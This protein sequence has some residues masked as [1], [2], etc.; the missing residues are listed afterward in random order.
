M[1]KAYKHETL[2]KMRSPALYVHR[3]LEDHQVDRPDVYAG[4]PAQPTGTNSQTLDRIDPALETHSER[5][6]G[7]PYRYLL[8][9]ERFPVTRPGWIHPFHIQVRKLGII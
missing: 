8:R 2:P 6:R 1:L 4:R 7:N 5:V 3:L 9:Q